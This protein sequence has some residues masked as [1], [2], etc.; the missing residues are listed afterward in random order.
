M[1]PV[2]EL[3]D[4]LTEVVGES[5]DEALLLRALTHRSY[6]YENDGQPHNERLEFLGDSV[7][8]VVVTDTLYRTHPDLT[9]G[10]LAKLRAAVVN[11][12]ALAEV[13][14]VVDLGAFVLLG[15]G[16][17]A[18]G[19]R[20]KDSILADTTEAVIGCVYLSAGLPAAATFVHHLL[21]P[22]M[23]R[24][25]GLGAGLD[26][27]TS[28]Q[29]VASAGDL[30]PPQYLVDAEGPD[31]DKTFTARAVVADEVVGTGVG[32][33]K[34]LAEQQ[35]AEQGWRLLTE[36]AAQ[37]VATEP[38]VEDLTGDGPGSG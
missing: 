18:T 20:D 3:A 8:G 32:R 31:H 24:S 37:V 34:K 17:Q 15:K 4:Y 23:R 38:T 13:A 10:Q 7:L 30:G 12:R 9:E 36:R 16:E 28:L 19:G 14:R 6:S 1:R 2:S 33:S 27:K 25:A 26:W 29:E 11:S 5:C 35:A 21:D 22:L